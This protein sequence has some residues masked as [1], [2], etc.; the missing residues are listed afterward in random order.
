MTEATIPATTSPEPVSQPSRVS[1]GWAYAK[2]SPKLVIGLLLLG[3]LLAL[4]LIGPMII[5]TSNAAPM[6]VRPDQGPNR[7]ELLGS[8]SQGRSLMSLLVEG[9]PITLRVGFLAG[10]IGLV[11]GTIL[12]LIAGYMGGV[13]D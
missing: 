1:T 6:S 11:I 4:W 7:T 10:T 9:V 8:D 5:D 13:V 3:S 12:G 2:R